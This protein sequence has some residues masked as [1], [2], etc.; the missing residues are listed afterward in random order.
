[1][2]PLVAVWRHILRAKKWRKS[3]SR[4]SIHN[5]WASI[6]DDLLVVRKKLRIKDIRCEIE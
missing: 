6:E 4:Q 5:E 1:M 3:D 2:I